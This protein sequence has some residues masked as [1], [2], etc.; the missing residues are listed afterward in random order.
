MAWIHMVG[1]R[2]YKLIMGA[3]M[4]RGS[5]LRIL[6]LDLCR[7][8]SARRVLAELH[9]PVAFTPSLQQ[10][11]ARQAIYGNLAPTTDNKIPK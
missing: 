4:P 3:V 10:R 8:L 6:D 2:R 11:R 1:I 7:I 9:R 5:A